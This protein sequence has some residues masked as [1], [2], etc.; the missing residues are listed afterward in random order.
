[1]IKSHLFLTE[2]A[3]VQPSAQGGCSRAA[4]CK[5]GGCLLACSV[6]TIKQNHFVPNSVSVRSFF[7]YWKLLSIKI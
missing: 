4:S 5:A 2:R 7:K 1:M 6:V 3:A